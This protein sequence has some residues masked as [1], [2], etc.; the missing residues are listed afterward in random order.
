[1]RS[2]PS[3]ATAV[4]AG[5]IKEGTTG[6]KRRF[7]E[8]TRAGARMMSSDQQ[9]VLLRD[10]D[11][12]AELRLETDMRFIKE[13]QK[14]AISEGN[15]GEDSHGGAAGEDDDEDGEGRPKSAVA[16]PHRSIKL[17]PILPHSESN[18]DDNVNFRLGMER[19]IQQQLTTSMHLPADL[20]T[21]GQKHQQQARR[22]KAAARAMRREAEL[23]RGVTVA[24]TAR[25]AE[26]NKLRLDAADLNRTFMGLASDHTDHEAN[27]TAI[28][29]SLEDVYSQMASVRKAT[30]QV[31]ETLGAW[32][33]HVMLE[34]M[35]DETRR[36]KE[37]TAGMSTDP[38]SG[39]MYSVIIATKGELLFAKSESSRPG[40]SAD[41]AKHAVVMQ[42]VGLFK[43]KDEAISAFR[44][45]C[46]KVPITNRILPYVDAPPMYV[47]LK[48]CGNHYL[49]RTD[50]IPPDLVCA[51]CETSARA[52]PRV[53]VPSLAS[54]LGAPTDNYKTTLPQFLWHGKNYIDK[55][56]DDCSF[57]NEN[58]A[59]NR[60][61]SDVDP[62]LNPLFLSGDDMKDLYGMLNAIQA[63]LVIDR[64]G[65][66][67]VLSH[68]KG[69]DELLADAKKASMWNHEDKTG[70]EHMG[71]AYRRLA[72]RSA[73]NLDRIE[74]YYDKPRNK[75]KPPENSL[76][77]EDISLFPLQSS[78]SIGS[79]G[80]RGTVDMHPEHG[81]PDDN[82]NDGGDGGHAHAAA[83]K[84][85]HT[86]RAE[87]E[88]IAWSLARKYLSV[89]EEL[90][91]ANT[92]V[93]PVGKSADF[94]V[95]KTSTV[96]FADETGEGV[97]DANAAAPPVR[98]NDE[99]SRLL[100]ALCVLSQ[101]QLADPIN[102]E[103]EVVKHVE[104]V[105]T[106][107]MSQT[108]QKDGSKK[109]KGKSVEMSKTAPDM[110]LP[111]SIQDYPEEYEVLATYDFKGARFQT[112]Q[113]RKALAHRKPTTWCRSDVGE[114]KG[115]TTKG[116][117]MKTFEFREQQLLEARLRAEERQRMQQLLRHAIDT[118]FI[119]CNVARIKELMTQAAPMKAL[120]LD[121]KA[122]ELFLQ[123]RSDAIK[124][125]T[126]IQR[127]W[128]RRRSRLIV[129]KF[130]ITVRKAQ[131]LRL[132]V[133]TEAAK[134]TKPYVSKLLDDVVT[135]I[136]K[137]LK[138]PLISCVF[139][140]RGR[141]IIANVYP[142]ARNA[143]KSRQV[144]ASCQAGPGEVIKLYIAEKHKR[145]PT[146]PPCTCGYRLEEERWHMRLYEPISSSMIS[147]TFTVSEII[148]LIMSSEQAALV[149]SQE[150]SE[151]M[152][153]SSSQ[154]SNL[155]R[156]LELGV[157]A[158]LTSGKALTDSD[159]E[160]MRAEALKDQVVAM[161]LGYTIAT[162]SDR[163][164]NHLLEE[165]R[166][167]ASDVINRF[168]FLTQNPKYKY[169]L[170]STS[171]DIISNA[172]GIITDSRS[173]A[174]KGHFGSH[175]D[176]YDGAVVPP[177]RRRVDQLRSAWYNTESWGAPLVL[178]STTRDAADEENA[179]DSR[180]EILKDII[181]S[182]HHIKRLEAGLAGIRAS[183][184]EAE[185]IWLDKKNKRL[186]Q[187]ECDL[188]PK[189]MYYEET[190]SRLLEYDREIAI[191]K[192]RIAKVMQFSK[193]KLEKFELETANIDEDRDEAWVPGDDGNAWVGLNKSRKLE[194][195][196]KIYVST[197]C[198]ALQT[199]QDSIRKQKE[200]RE[201]ENK[202]FEWKEF[203]LA[204]YRAMQE[205]YEMT[206][207][208]NSEL[209]SMGRDAWRSAMSRLCIGR[210]PG[211]P[212]GQLRVT[213]PCLDLAYI[214][215]P[216]KR[217][218]RIMR[219]HWEM[220]KRKA[221]RLTPWDIM[222]EHF[223]VPFSWWNSDDSSA[224]SIVRFGDDIT[225]FN[226]S[227][228]FP[229]GNA[230]NHI[231]ASV[232]KDPMTG[233]F[234]VE[235]GQNLKFSGDSDDF[236]AVP[237]ENAIESRGFTI[238]DAVRS[239]INSCYPTDILLTPEELSIL[240][241]MRNSAFHGSYAAAGTATPSRRLRSRRLRERSSNTKTP[242]TGSLATTTK[243]GAIRAVSYPRT[244][245]KVKVLERTYNRRRLADDASV[246][247]DAEFLLSL[248]RLNPYSGRVSL[249]KLTLMRRS[250][251]VDTALQA[252]LWYRDW[253]TDES[254]SSWANEQANYLH[255]Y[256]NRFCNIRVRDA[257]GSVEVIISF[258]GYDAVAVSV[259][260][261]LEDIIRS[262]AGRPLLLATLFCDILLNKY[263]SDVIQHIVSCI[264]LEVPGEMQRR[265][266][267]WELA[268]EVPL[269]LYS[270]DRLLRYR[271]IFKTHRFL[272]G[273]YFFVQLSLSAT[274]EFLV[275]LRPPI[276]GQFSS[277]AH[278]GE[279]YS[280]ELSVGELRSI[281]VRYHMMH[282]GN[283]SKATQSGQDFIFNLLH[284][285]YFGDLLEFLLQRL[286]TP[287]ETGLQADGDASLELEDSDIGSYLDDGSI[288]ASLDSRA[289]QLGPN[290]R[291]VAIP[292]FREESYPS[293]GL[294]SRRGSVT[295]VGE[296][297][298][299][300]SS[301]DDA[302]AASAGS[303]DTHL[304]GGTDTSLKL[305]KNIVIA[306]EIFEKWLE[307]RKN[308]NLEEDLKYQVASEFV[309]QLS[310]YK[311]L[312]DDAE[313]EKRC[314][315]LVAMYPKIKAKSDVTAE[316]T[317]NTDQ[318]R[319][320]IL[321]PDP[322]ASMGANESS[323]QTAAALK[324]KTLVG[325]H[326][327][328]LVA[329]DSLR[330]PTNIMMKETASIETR[331]SI[332]IPPGIGPQSYWNLRV[333][334]S[335]DKTYLV[336]HASPAGVEQESAQA[337]LT[338]KELEDM[339][340]EDE[341]TRRANE[342]FKARVTDQEAELEEAWITKQASLC[343]ADA[344]SRAGRLRHIID[345]LKREQSQVLPTFDAWITK[346]ALY[347]HKI[348]TDALG[349]DADN[350]ATVNLT[351]Q[352]YY[353]KPVFEVLKA[354]GTD[355]EIAAYMKTSLPE[356]LVSV[357]PHIASETMWLLH[358][359]KSALSTVDVGPLLR[360]AR[361]T[362]RGA[363]SGVT[364]LYQRPCRG[365]R[366]K[367]ARV[368]E[369]D[370]HRDLLPSQVKVDYKRTYTI[371]MDYSVDKHVFTRR[372][373]CSCTGNCPHR[374]IKSDFHDPRAWRR[375]SSDGVCAW[376]DGALRSID[377]KFV[378]KARV[379][380][381][382]KKVRTASGSLVYAS[383]P[384][385]G[386]FDATTLYLYDPSSQRSWNAQLDAPFVP[387]VSLSG[388]N[389]SESSR[390]ADDI[391][392]NMAKDAAKRIVLRSLVHGVS[393]AVL[394]SCCKSI[395][396][397]IRRVESQAGEVMTK[398]HD[399][400]EEEHRARLRPKV[401]S[402]TYRLRDG[403]EKSFG[404]TDP[405]L[406]EACRDNLVPSVKRIRIRGVF[407]PADE[408]QVPEV[409]EAD[410][411]LWYAQLRRSLEPENDAADVYPDEFDRAVA[412]GALV[413]T[414]K[415]LIGV[416]AEKCAQ[417][418]GTRANARLSR[419][420]FEE[421]MRSIQHGAGARQMD[422]ED[423]MPAIFGDAVVVLRNPSDEVLS[424]LL[425]WCSSRKDS[426]N[427]ALAN[428]HAS[429][430]HNIND[431]LKNFINYRNLI[432]YWTRRFRPLFN[433]IFGVVGRKLTVESPFDKDEFYRES[434]V[435]SGTSTDSG[436][437]PVDF[438][439]ALDG[440]VVSGGDFRCLLESLVTQLQEH[441]RSSSSAHQSKVESS[442]LGGAFLLDEEVADNGD[443]ELLRTIDQYERDPNVRC[444]S[445]K[446]F[447]SYDLDDLRMRYLLSRY[448]H[449]ETFDYSICKES[450]QFLRF[451][452]AAFA[453]EGSS[454][455]DTIA[456]PRPT[457]PQIFYYL[458]RNHCLDCDCP[459]SF[460]PVPG[461][462]QIKQQIWSEK[463]AVQDA[464]LGSGKHVA[465]IAVRRFMMTGLA[466]S[467]S[468]CIFLA[469]IS[470]V[471]PVRSVNWEAT[472]V[473]S[474][475]K[476]SKKTHTINWRDIDG[477][478]SLIRTMGRYLVAP[479]VL[480]V[481]SAGGAFQMGTSGIHHTQEEHDND[482]AKVLCRH[483][484]ALELRRLRYESYNG[485]GARA[486]P[487]ANAASA[488]ASPMSVQVC[489]PLNIIQAIYA[490]MK[491]FIRMDG[492]TDS[493]V[494]TGL[495]YLSSYQKSGD[496]FDPYPSAASQALT[497]TAHP[498]ESSAHAMTASD[499]QWLRKRVVVFRRAE[500]P[501]FGTPSSRSESPRVVAVNSNS[502]A[503]I[504]PVIGI[505]RLYFYK[506][507]YFDE[508]AR[509][510]YAFSL[511]DG[512]PGSSALKMIDGCLVQVQI[513]YGVLPGAS[514][515]SSEH[516][517]CPPAAKRYFEAEELGRVQ[518]GLTLNVYEYQSKVSR[519]VL[520]H[521]ALL[522]SLSK[523]LGG[524]YWDLSDLA[525][526]IYYCLEIILV[527]VRTGSTC[528][529]VELDPTIL[530]TLGHSPDQG[531]KTQKGNDDGALVDGVD[532]FDKE[533]RGLSSR[534]N[535]AKVCTMGE[536]SQPQSGLDHDDTK[537]KATPLCYQPSFMETA[538][539]RVRHRGITG[540]RAALT[541]TRLASAAAAARL[542]LQEDDV[543]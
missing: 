516:N 66:L 58:D 16:A 354:I 404:I 484:H 443:A 383:E 55:I 336:L 504:E 61:R 450:D 364:L 279:G 531:N 340:V 62:G 236:S 409:V 275:A 165:L 176:S 345:I 225:P 536:S 507:F 24:I 46:V 446:I 136:T 244:R 13:L 394:H 469:P 197:V 423:V 248:L 334:T 530:T 495:R 10:E 124:A 201:E 449:F 70:F 188:D 399:A 131:K 415:G 137:E 311:V 7:L 205:V 339:A 421:N 9:S 407:M 268:G 459:V 45:A 3:S 253:T 15:E 214:R 502:S 303:D 288:D 4:P 476:F 493:I 183:F 114:W 242:T 456:I 163:P 232:Y 179:P 259:F 28:F 297:V 120:A 202:A 396:S 87:A 212:N 300:A 11:L 314:W 39:R 181:D 170:Q 240:R 172:I 296:E 219:S 106:Q 461:C 115:L 462:V 513:L 305:L 89:P 386:P 295:S 457:A 173:L 107:S 416:N 88:S 374:S 332:Y 138:R 230:S 285:E 139:G 465:D 31:L 524:R 159:G 193:R 486:N 328:L 306:T 38:R 146:R 147:R 509:K 499:F 426:L 1:M 398:A 540:T 299:F 375:T 348:G 19:N 316:A 410:A 229:M 25:E 235:L 91:P 400:I 109:T 454:P 196:A 366:S 347:V 122:A 351:A 247:A 425:A 251:S 59:L 518:H 514:A 74:A 361:R 357:S 133:E 206:K 191:E 528:T 132:L 522:N 335:E 370:A 326:E 169:L 318:E 65:D 535:T 382:S 350:N 274:E 41:P 358:S 249:G 307:E 385:I 355:A 526:R 90:V 480:R 148:S 342:V 455:E 304:D 254:P 331:S 75:V 432:K 490:G 167:F 237:E 125:C 17:K 479:S 276:D 537:A 463:H 180:W 23:S 523:A 105:R 20:Q 29:R 319:R 298:D 292:E 406:R 478:K 491:S 27:K 388:V 164:T 135:S 532:G 428:R 222:N 266:R 77:L 43:T 485:D 321:L 393:A 506:N 464:E 149:T 67:K 363:L 155:E 84:A 261:P 380:T 130:Q 255:V 471:P 93:R 434:I 234:I 30:V 221:R 102:F 302:D 118:D 283:R 427:R 337:V 538:A 113:T 126:K 26:L 472:A 73:P 451:Q 185:A 529:G 367:P 497:T 417:T 440:I 429:V 198:D 452:H 186:V 37:E 362:D 51:E 418:I 223:P 444:D 257:V 272:F 431:R 435:K 294:R 217:N 389:E 189:M 262:M 250:V 453:T 218:L 233:N 281:V 263:S 241:K 481:V 162:M 470:K 22:G 101:S 194:M 343:V 231:A 76:T 57:L 200:C 403:S 8:V 123:K 291:F 441:T 520:V 329:L 96:R 14:A 216:R 119:S 377:P 110:K 413:Y 71:V 52:Q 542:L 475:S 228:R 145:V 154:L 151:N 308:S 543:E 527:I 349:V 112:V 184:E 100:R 525:R 157:L 317:A 323:G 60:Y 312:N 171:S 360:S 53:M 104:T 510:R 487:G 269:M 371:D 289:P 494:K 267:R 116:P 78:V 359:L 245:E 436:G 174:L 405:A 111:D 341:L 411:E 445:S 243:A 424:K 142:T 273:E 6:F 21:S 207:K 68:L 327:G 466:E 260:V 18:I 474:T 141:S 47:G 271:P 442:T 365:A 284:P 290:T 177:L 384:V 419:W 81:S 127:Y 353:R 153:F 48:S 315:P 82:D 301:V 501:G 264:D 238:S 391:R 447:N 482:S 324:G 158:Q 117:N 379:G 430:I 187:F 220:I 50:M 372:T 168:D 330:Y 392:V 99:K 438:S 519:A 166:G 333:A 505:D 473:T 483:V 144:C 143:L 346:R 293:E 33:R 539:R 280:I 211:V 150:H 512:T 213:A 95:A 49:V 378:P 224:G 310:E 412:M 56:W 402:R 278:R 103:E 322:K 256:N 199:L 492:E 121:I 437:V 515:I 44:H 85:A 458:I 239:M 344:K 80:A 395:E 210:S 108:Q 63:D 477:A 94:P 34:Q 369:P 161:R 521:G 208:V 160:Q 500:Q 134:F 511:I 356:D 140:M 98:L 72:S 36:H 433:R 376:E 79:P 368:D 517:G 387:P 252:S 448:Q 69:Q 182:R 152:V 227:S 195:E 175:D 83:D 496:V 35:R 203:V 338:D 32:A 156:Q 97:S 352:K 178:A 246:A 86:S 309:D 92:S 503:A 541:D 277:R 313:K 325:V 12:R 373:P 286:D 488:A 390:E 489:I 204:A 265:L 468:T 414:R 42:Y 534:P 508:R 320:L 54:A 2:H 401:L 420:V 439:A 40:E 190:L 128:R 381:Q 226:Y 129:R 533:N 460:C 408:D 287:F 270:P 397:E 498:A 258:Y 422:V 467:V 209:E 282:S 5:Q 192:A 215:D 64:G